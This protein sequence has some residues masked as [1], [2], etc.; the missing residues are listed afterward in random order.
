MKSRQKP[1]AA[2]LVHYLYMQ[3]LGESILFGG[4]KIMYPSAI[5]HIIYTSIRKKVEVVY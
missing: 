4:G 5:Q 1:F 3:A 2:R